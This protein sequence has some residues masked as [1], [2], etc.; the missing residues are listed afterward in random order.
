[1]KNLAAA[2]LLATSSMVSP[3]TGAA[4]PSP[5]TTSTIPILGENEVASVRARYEAG[6]FDAFLREMD[7]PYREAQKGGAIESLSDMRKNS[8]PLAQEGAA[9]AI[10]QER[11]QK[12]LALAGEQKG[13]FFD[14]V[15]S[16]ASE[17]L[18][19]EDFGYLRHKELGS[20]KNGDENQLIALDVEYEYKILHLDRPSV[21]G[22][23][24]ENRKEKVLAL[25]M[26]KGDKMEEAASKFSDSALQARVT[27]YVA[28]LDHLLAQRCDAADLL[29]LQRQGIRGGGS[30]VEQQ[31]LLIMQEAQDQ[32]LSLDSASNGT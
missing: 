9:R 12:L 13:A 26:Q 29:S 30:L 10:I 11:N 28:H 22:K 32:L 4:M 15:R 23:S 14:K 3:L 18:S 27:S 17:D 19:Q 2:L 20:G 5:S 31:V 8:A 16:M 25:R 21:E 7:V 24:V 6:D 1:M